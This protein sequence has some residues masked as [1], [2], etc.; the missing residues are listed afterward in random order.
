MAWVRTCPGYLETLSLA[1][2]SFISVYPKGE[3]LNYLFYFKIT[4]QSSFVSS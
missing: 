4:T 3:W 1:T 2:I